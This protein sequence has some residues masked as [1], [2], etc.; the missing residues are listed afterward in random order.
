MLDAEHGNAHRMIH[1]CIRSSW[2]CRTQEE[3]DLSSSQLVSCEGHFTSCRE[4]SSKRWAHRNTS[5]VLMGGT[6]EERNSWLCGDS[7]LVKNRSWDMAIRSGHWQVSDVLW[8]LWLDDWKRGCVRCWCVVQQF[9]FLHL[10]ASGGQW[11]REFLW[12][13]G[14]K[15]DGMH[16]LALLS[17]DCHPRVGNW[18]YVG[19][20]NISFYWCCNTMLRCAG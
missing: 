13:K 2:H 4:K 15:N 6:D 9:C 5:Q 12:K 17:S 11:K 8:Q 3:E 16:E 14:K 20:K 7:L 19:V 10:F 1:I 18:N